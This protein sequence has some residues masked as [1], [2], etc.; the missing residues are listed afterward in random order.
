MNKKEAIALLKS[1]IG[2]IENLDEDEFQDLFHK[3]GRSY[4][5]VIP[6]SYGAKKFSK[7]KSEAVTRLT[8]E[9]LKMLT[10]K[11]QACANR[12]S[13]LLI[14]KEDSRLNSKNNLNDFA[15]FLKVHIKKDD[16]RESIENK[17]IEYVVGTKLRSEAILGLNYKGQ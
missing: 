14:M 2:I 17:I 16:T 15:R 13:A 9:D 8:I 6:K 11:L 10:G 4:S 3:V 7:V 5:P 1:L 12:D